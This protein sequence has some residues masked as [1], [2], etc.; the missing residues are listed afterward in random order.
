[1]ILLLDPVE[2]TPIALL[3]DPDARLSGDQRP[4]VLQTVWDNLAAIGLPRLRLVDAL[5]EFWVQPAS[6]KTFVRGPEAYSG[7]GT[8]LSARDWA[9][10]PATDRQAYR[11]DPGLR[12]APTPTS[13]TPPG[14]GQMQL[15]GSAGSLQLAWNGVAG[16][17]Y[18][19]Y[20]TPNLTRPFALTETLIAAQDGSLQIVLPTAGSQ[21][22]YRLAEVV[23]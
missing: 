21:G 5:P 3:S 16:R 20:H 4:L 11:L 8:E 10:M 18:Q 12:P 17:V 2:H 15:G 19:V 14:G 13:L 6:L 1:M 9:G 22:F 7:I 23:P